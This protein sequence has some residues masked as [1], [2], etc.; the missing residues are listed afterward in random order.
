MVE[1]ER[2]KVDVVKIDLS[3]TEAVHR[4]S[5]RSTGSAEDKIGVVSLR[6]SEST[7]R[8]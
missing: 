4:W 1:V 7:T 3:R 6:V 5:F 2:I 8:R